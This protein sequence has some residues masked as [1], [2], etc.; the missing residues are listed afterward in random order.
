MYVFDL[1]GKIIEEHNSVS[2]YARNRHVTPNS[3]FN[4]IYSGRIYRGKYFLSY[5][6]FFTPDASINNINNNQTSFYIYKKVN[7]K[8]SLVYVASSKASCS[9]FIEDNTGKHIDDVTPYINNN[10][11]IVNE[12]CIHTTNKYELNK[13]EK[14]ITL[15]YHLNNI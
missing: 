8:I 14:A 6:K 12:F 15:E 5:D 10:R 4:Y 11:F 1:D 2:E 7:G 3:V 9:E 13:L